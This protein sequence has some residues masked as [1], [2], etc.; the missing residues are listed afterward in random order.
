M[1]TPPLDIID[2]PADMFHYAPALTLTPMWIVLHATAGTNSL[3][4][5]TTTSDPP[6]SVHRL[7]DRMGRIFKIVPDDR[8]A[9]HVGKAILLPGPLKALTN[10]NSICL[11]IELENLNDGTQ[12]YP[13]EQVDATA[14]QITEWWGAYG[15]LPVV[16]HA[17][18]DVRKSD[19]YRFPWPRLAHSLF[20]SAAG[21]DY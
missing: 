2:A 15:Y 8:Q 16:S 6:V 13:Q 1:K 4:W 17:A 14:R 3:D 18:L 20:R 10:P 9:W 12:D 21:L 5:L 7:I 19:P 11:G